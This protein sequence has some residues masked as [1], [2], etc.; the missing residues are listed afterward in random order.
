MATISFTIPD[1]KYSGLVSAIKAI[2]PNDELNE[3]GSAKYTDND[4]A[5][6]VIR[7]SIVSLEARGRQRLAVLEC[8]YCQDEEVVS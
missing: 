8:F 7:R 3:D 5:R 1:D 4:W 2:H 6:E